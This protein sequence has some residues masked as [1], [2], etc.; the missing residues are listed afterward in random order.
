MVVE[1]LYKR[2][3]STG[4]R[5]RQGVI[6]LEIDVMN[7]SAPEDQLLGLCQIAGLRCQT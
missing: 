6:T 1:P 3:M 5:Q 7:I 4:S 2:Q